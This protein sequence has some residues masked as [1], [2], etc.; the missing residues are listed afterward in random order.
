MVRPLSGRISLLPGTLT[1]TSAS[2]ASVATGDTVVIGSAV[3]GLP[4]D[5]LTIA[6]MHDP[7]FPTG[8]TVRLDAQG[9]ILYRPGPIGSAQAGT[10]LVQYA[11]TD[12]ATHE[13]VSAT[14]SV[15]LIGRD[16]L[17]D[18]AY[19]L[20][21]NPDVAAAGADPLQHYLA[22]GWKEG[23]DPSA[24]F[25]TNYYLK[26]NPD[27]AAAGVNPL[28]HF[29]THG[30]REGR[31]PSLVFDDAKYLAANP[32]VAAAGVDPLQ[33]FMTYG[34]NEGRAS[35]LTGGATAADP[36]V[37]TAYYDQQL[38]ATLIPG[39]A[40]GAQQ[41]AYSYD[42]AGWLKGLNPDALFDTPYYLAHNPDVAAAYID[43]LRH[44]EAYGW[45]EGRDPSAT[46]STDKYLA[47]YADVK[48]AGI[49]PLLH[50]VAYGQGEGRSLFGA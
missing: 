34:Q 29:E 13:T 28:V 41:A 40:A 23:R 1:L 36:L 46:F 37:S 14:Q 45:K 6:L 27:V 24:C 7:A 33:H 11:V 8:S 48:G 31:Q 35:F 16:P 9:N 10:D 42:A 26:Q 47:A 2:A 43:P 50:Y 19:Y 49:D 15:T 12:A 38:G 3:A 44:Y 30:W 5:P 4:G 17:F 22:Y 20:A 32:D 25:D 21:H 18:A 39:G